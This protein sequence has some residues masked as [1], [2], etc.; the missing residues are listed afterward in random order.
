MFYERMVVHCREEGCIELYNLNDYEI[1][2]GSRDV[3]RVGV[4]NKYVITT[5]LII[6]LSLS[7]S[8][9]TDNSFKSPIMD[10]GY[11]SFCFEDY[12]FCSTLHSERSA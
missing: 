6:L 2:Q 11:P 9:I 1:S 8:I 12:N 7:I 10:N 4:Y 3:P 5:F